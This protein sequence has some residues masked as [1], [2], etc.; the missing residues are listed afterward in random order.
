[1]SSFSQ[2]LSGIHYSQDLVAKR[3]TMRFVP[4][5]ALGGPGLPAP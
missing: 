5:I 2:G 3:L 1:M 4:I